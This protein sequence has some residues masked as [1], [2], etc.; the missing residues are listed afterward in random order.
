MLPIIIDNLIKEAA[1]SVKVL[2]TSDR[3]F[4]VTYAEDKVSVA[5]SFKKLVSDGVYKSP[6]W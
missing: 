4:G 5:A 3:W 2:E 1:V 6:L